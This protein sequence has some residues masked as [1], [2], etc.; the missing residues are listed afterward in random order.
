[1]VSN[2][3]VRDVMPIYTVEKEVFRTIVEALN[4]RYQL[5]C[6]GSF[7][8][9]AIPELYERTQEQIAAKEKKNY[10]YHQPMVIMYFRCVSLYY[11]PLCR[12]SVEFTKPLPSGKLH[13]QFRLGHQ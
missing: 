4:P 8:R 3:I 9:T 6:K 1:M 7:S 10:R 5:S 12:F 2:F 13:T 11:N